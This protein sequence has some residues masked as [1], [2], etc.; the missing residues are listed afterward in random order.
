MDG[1]EWLAWIDA[2][3]FLRLNANND[4]EIDEDLLEFAGDWFR[5]LQDYGKKTFHR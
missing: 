3:S 4:R 5:E 2:L 1:D